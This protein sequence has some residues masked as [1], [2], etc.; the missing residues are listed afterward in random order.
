MTPVQEVS[1]PVNLQH[2]QSL[3]GVSS[4][5]DVKIND[6]GKLEK[7]SGIRAL[8]AR[9]GEFFQSLS[10]G[11]R[12]AIAARN[13]AVV[14]AMRQA[15]NGVQT[16]YTYTA[17]T[18]YG[19]LYTIT[20]ETRVEGE[21]VE[22]QSRR[23]VKFINE[24]G[25]TVREEEYVLL[26]GGTWA[27]ISGVT[28]IVLG[29]SPRRRSLFPAK[30][31]VDQLNT[32]APDLDIYIIPDQPAPRPFSL[33]RPTDFSISG[34]SRPDIFRMLAI[35]ALC[36]AVG[37]L[38]L[39]LGF[40]S[41]NIIMVYILGV[42]A[43][44]M[45]TSGRRYSLLSSVLSVLIFNFFF[46]FPYFSLMSDPGYLATFA[47]M[48]LVAILGSSLTTRLKQQAA[49]NAEKAYRTEILLETSQK[50]QPPASTHIL[51]SHA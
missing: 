16:W 20:E 9:I 28:K 5:S 15:V 4:L 6:S 44:A 41:A 35:L 1:M 31:L 50:L 19:A 2:L 45:V 18:S 26:P 24:A 39:R 23:S 38:F 13:E 43:I 27:K 30:S 29:R 42:L 36:S 32:L 10:A 8:F 46:T 14:S 47:V 49:Q 22:G 12:A 37:F 11:G 51:C 40:N 34:F 17:A 3:L 7:R 48:F 33:P 21:A 25:N